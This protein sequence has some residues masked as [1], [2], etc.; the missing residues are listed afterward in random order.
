MQ[1]PAKVS[2]SGCEQN[3]SVDHEHG[4]IWPSLGSEHLRPFQIIATFKHSIGK[5]GG[6]NECTGLR[7]TATAGEGF[8][9][10]CHGPYPASFERT[11]NIKLWNEFSRL[12]AN[13]LLDGK[14]PSHSEKR[15]GQTVEGTQLPRATILGVISH[16]RTHTPKQGRQAVT[17]GW[18]IILP[19]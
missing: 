9:A 19:T 17:G 14:N 4:Q 5:L 15:Q 2:N 6:R 11:L 18:G 7:G 10:I 12:P 3:T 13:V 1:P 16:T 8:G